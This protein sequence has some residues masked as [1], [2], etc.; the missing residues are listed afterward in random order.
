MTD[1]IADFLT[2]IRNACQV[3]KKYVD[4][5]ESRMKRELSKILVEERFVSRY[6]RIRDDKQGIIRLYLK[7]TPD[8]KSVIDTLQRMSRPGRRIYYRVDKIPRILNGLGVMILTTPK[9]VLTDRQARKR[10]VGGEPLCK[11]W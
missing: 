4:V 7:Y 1:P 10:R 11:L 3:G 6:I 9:G 2:R 8:G 5:P